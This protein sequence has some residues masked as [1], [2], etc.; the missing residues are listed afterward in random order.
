MDAVVYLVEALC[1]K[2]E[3]RAFDSR[4]S[5]WI[6]QVTWT[7]QPQYGTWVYSASNGNEYQ[8][9]FLA[10]KRCRRVKLTT[11][12]P[13]MSRLSKQGYLYFCIVKLFNMRQYSVLT[14]RAYRHHFP[15]FSCSIS[16]SN[17]AVTWK[18][19]PRLVGWMLALCLMQGRIVLYKLHL[20]ILYKLPLLHSLRNWSPLNLEGCMALVGIWVPDESDFVNVDTSLFTS[21]H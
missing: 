18:E 11:R 12:P 14:P 7:L 3:Y 19:R 10:L 5:H 13:S 15:C 2:L 9:L 6:F 20:H 21:V 16:V 1:Y 4:W 8:K 17:I